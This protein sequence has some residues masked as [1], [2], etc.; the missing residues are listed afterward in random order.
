[1]V[2]GI[3]EK[4]SQNNFTIN[5]QKPCKK[6]FSC[7]IR[8]KLIPGQEEKYCLLEEKSKDCGHYYK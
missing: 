8:P 5:G 7:R 3:E 6:Y 4:V 1:M 2:E